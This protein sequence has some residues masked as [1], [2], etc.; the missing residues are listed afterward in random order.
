[1]KTYAANITKWSQGYFHLVMKELHRTA[2]N[3]FGIEQASAM[4]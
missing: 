2:I 4:W 1:M 3:V